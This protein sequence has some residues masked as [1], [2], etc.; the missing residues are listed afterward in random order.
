MFCPKCGKELENYARFCG[1]CGSTVT[2]KIP[3]QP[4][5]INNLKNTIP[6]KEGLDGLKKYFTLR[7]NYQSL[8]FKWALILLL[9][10]GLGDAVENILLSITPLYN[11]LHNIIPSGGLWQLLITGLFFAVFVPIILLKKVKKTAK[12]SALI[13]TLWLIAILLNALRF[14]AS[15]EFFGLTNYILYPNIIGNC[16][17][18]MLAVFTTLYLYKNKPQYPIP[19]I[20]SAASVAMW[21]SS[22]QHFTQTAMWYRLDKAFE[23]KTAYRDMWDMILNNEGLSYIFL[24]ICLFAIRYLLPEKVG[25]CLVWIPALAVQIYQTIILI[26]YFSWYRLCD[27]GLDIAVTVLFVLFSLCCSKNAEYDYAVEHMLS[28]KKRVIVGIVSVISTAVIA[29][30][31]LLSSEIIVASQINSGIEKWKDEIIEGNVLGEEWDAVQKDIFGMKSLIKMPSHFITDYDFYTELQQY[32]YKMEMISECYEKYVRGYVTAEMGDKFTSLLIDDSWE[33]DSVLSVY[34]DRYMKMK[35][36]KEKVS[37]SSKIDI[38][39][40]KIIVT[41]KNKN[42]MP[43]KGCTVKCDFTILYIT[44][45]YYSDNEYGRGTRS[46]T[47]EEI[48]ANSEKIEE[49]YFDPDEYYN[50]YSSYL[51]ATVFQQNVSLESLQ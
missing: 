42:I 45:G 4:F 24:V 1:N 35:P 11:I 6:V 51:M 43:I 7:V 25:K 46:V 8:F 10:I 32:R 40:K 12:K 34:Y 47:V 13:S 37:V 31:L 23:L 28:G 9:A 18:V 44:G 49:V 5:N 29:S 26:Q 3:R 33:N 22:I 15:S 2:K 41:V 30:T 50:R 19:L 21:Q 48:P 27:Y 17:T 14:L 38:S 36:T 20:I 39:G 16:L